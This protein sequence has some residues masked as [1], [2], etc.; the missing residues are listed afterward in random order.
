[1]NKHTTLYLT[2]DDLKEQSKDKK[3]SEINWWDFKQSLYKMITQNVVIYKSPLN[4][5]KILM[6]RFGKAH[7]RM[8]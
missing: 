1:M 5:E 8:E 7:L 3:Y 2:N 6:N 4:E